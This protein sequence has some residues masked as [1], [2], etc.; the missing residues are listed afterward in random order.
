MIGRRSTSRLALAGLFLLACAGTASPANEEPNLTFGARFGGTALPQCPDARLVIEFSGGNATGTSFG[1][2]GAVRVDKQGAVV[3]Y[4]RA[5]CL[6]TVTV[7][8]EQWS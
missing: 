5:D 4:R 3:T 8:R 2:A 7:R 1:A 6:F